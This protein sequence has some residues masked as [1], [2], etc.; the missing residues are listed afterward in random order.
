[1]S[2]LFTASVRSPM[3]GV[4]LTLELTGAYAVALPLLATCLA[5]SLVARAL[6]GSPIYEQL[7]DSTLRLAGA[8]KTN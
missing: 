6:G 1:M 4:V 2:G 7:R 3:V 8:L 5:A